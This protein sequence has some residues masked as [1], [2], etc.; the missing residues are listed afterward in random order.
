MTFY[1][2]DKQTLILNVRACPGAKRE[3]FE[4]VWNKTHL[5]VAL[6]A[7]AV[8]GKANE[9]LIAFLSDAFRVKK[10]DVTLI[11]GQTARL[12][13]VKIEN[14]P[15]NIADFLKYFISDYDE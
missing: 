14:S 1:M 15:V 12:K 7:R 6:R 2:L 8:D 9:A 13:K 4:G 5:K 10:S 3:G 11:T